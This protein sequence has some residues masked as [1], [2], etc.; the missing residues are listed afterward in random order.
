MAH[1]TDRSA[2]DF[3]PRAAEPVRAHLAAATAL[4]AFL[5]GAGT[6]T[7]A[8]RRLIVDQ[9]LTM[10]DQNYVHLPL[11]SAM[12]AVNPVQ[13][14]RVLHRR[15]ERQTEATKPLEWLFHAELSEIFHSVRDLH[16][17]YLLPAPTQARSPSCR[18]SS[19]GTR[20]RRGNT[21]WSPTWPR[22][23]PPRVSRPASRSPIGAG[24]PSPRPSTSTQPA[25]PAATRPPAA[26][27]ASS[28]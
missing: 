4:P 8:E 20:T 14:L 16:T 6:L 15:L 17:N 23:S 25:S 24:S 26:A 18:S 28:R 1:P 21:S 19:S 11:K 22:D 13:R 9:A 2:P 10:L 27:A 3:V 5:A 7:L 12:Y